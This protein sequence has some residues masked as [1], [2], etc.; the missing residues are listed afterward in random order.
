VA[1]GVV[2]AA[3]GIDTAG[4]VRVSA[5]WNNLIGLKPQ[6]GR[7][8]TAPLAESCHGLGGYGVLAT[9]AHDAAAVVAAVMGH[10]QTDRHTPPTIRLAELHD[11]ITAPLTIAVSDRC[12]SPFG[13]VTVDR[14]IRRQMD[15]MCCTLED[16]GHRVVSGM[17]NY[18]GSLWW[19][20]AVRAA[21]GLFES[22]Q[23]LGGIA[24]VGDPQTRTRA[25]IGF[26]L[27][28]ATLRKARARETGIRRRMRA[29][30]DHADVLLTPTA[31]TPAPALPV[32]A[33]TSTVTD[34]RRAAGACP[35]TWAWNVLGWPALTVP[36]GFTDA[37]LPVGVQLMG[38]PNSEPMLLALANSVEALTGYAH[39]RPAP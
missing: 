15:N 4:E 17:A 26:L 22:T 32:P 39:R 5:A 2:A 9:T 10:T 24:A 16:L 11:I 8:S 19:N 33:R 38:P 18:G 3:I 31:A 20:F 23:R 7:I 25:R 35:F 1:A 27:S 12:P 34:L 13:H 37:G 14:Q 6:R 30:F 29:V 21:A 28:E 36:A